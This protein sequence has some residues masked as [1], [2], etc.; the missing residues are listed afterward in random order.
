LVIFGENV[1]RSAPEREREREREKD[2]HRK[3]DTQPYVE[4]IS[5]YIPST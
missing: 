5:K 1:V 4:E 2:R 3:T